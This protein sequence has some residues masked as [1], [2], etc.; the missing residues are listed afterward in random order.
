M[1]IY[2]QN[3]NRNFVNNVTLTVTNHLKTNQFDNYVNNK[4]NKSI[5]HEPLETEKDNKQTRINA[6]ALLIQTEN[7]KNNLLKESVENH[8]KPTET[9]NNV[10]SLIGFFNMV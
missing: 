2:D 1:N 4:D 6:K 9:N 10:P 8:E 3:L 7:I 5:K